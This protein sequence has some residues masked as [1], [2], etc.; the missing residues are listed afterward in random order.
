MINQNCAGLPALEK[1]ILNQNQIEYIYYSGGFANLEALSIENNLLNSWNSMDELM[2]F[3]RGIKELRVAGNTGIQGTM[4]VS[5]FRFMIIGRLGE[6]KLL[7]GS[8]VRNQERIDAERY[9]LRSN[10]EDLDAMNTPRW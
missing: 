3:P 4:R 10:N 6:L 8:A 1:L 2:K 5:L 9:Y 7:N